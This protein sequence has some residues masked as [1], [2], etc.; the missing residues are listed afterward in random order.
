ME[1]DNLTD[2]QKVVI[3]HPGE[4]FVEACPGSGKTE[5]IAHRVARNGVL[6]PPRRGIALLTFTNSAVDEF[7]SRCKNAGLA[8]F[9]SHP[10]YVGTFDSFIRNFVFLPTCISQVEV[11]PNIID[12]WK[13]LGVEV[14]LRG[15]NAF[16]GPG[17]D[18]DLFDPSTEQINLERIGHRGLRAHVERQRQEYERAARFRRQGLNNKGMYSSE[19]I[20]SVARE[21]IT[22]QSW[23][24]PLGAAIAARF[25]EIIVDEAQDCN[26]ADTEL[27]SW[28]RDQGIPVTLVCDA[29]QSIY[30]FRQGVPTN[31][32]NYRDTYLAER[33]LALTGNFRS[34][35]AICRAAATLRARR[36]P[37][38]SLSE[39]RDVASP[40]H[41][42][43]HQG[44]IN[45]NIGTA[46]LSRAAEVGIEPT[47]CIVLAHGRRTANKAVGF[48]DFVSEGTSNIEKLAKSIVGFNS[49]SGREREVAL[50]GI[51]R[52]ILNLL[53]QIDAGESVQHA[54]EKAGIER[55]IL[56]RQALSIATTLQRLS[57]ITDDDRELWLR[58]AREAFVRLD[59]PLPAGASINRSFQ[60]GNGRWARRLVLAANSILASAKTVHD[61]K[62]QEYDAACIVIPAEG[63]RTEALMNSWENVLEFEAK[64]VVYVGATRAQKLLAIAIPL[65]LRERIT[66]I[67]DANGVPY[68]ESRV[69]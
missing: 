38:A 3:S 15:R 23:A 21:R 27:I 67:F 17:V 11:K 48:S 58:Q 35:P 16:Q 18:L 69:D 37:D 39:R 29:D 5:T 47:D 43:T 55:R 8:N 25:A 46:F 24:A 68:D 63:E 49:S 7:L 33:R 50:Q 10:D 53:Q 56:R 65:N 12:S 45:I 52:L 66:A 51:E 13:T 57:G 41:L 64:R 14:R 36:A 20:R 28:L 2:E 54:V 40:I 62:G 19:D 22:N 44:E 6:L 34:S 1:Y 9:G 31:I 61:A 32:R 60:A 42:I 59:L 30:G 26:D 4:A